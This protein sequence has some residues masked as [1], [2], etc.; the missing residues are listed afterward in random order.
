MAG[1]VRF[2]KLVL[3]SP[4]KNYFVDF[5]AG[6]NLIAGPMYTGKS[7][8]LELLDYALG[9]STPPNYPELAKCS[10]VLVELVVNGETL[11]LR[12]NLKSTSARAQLYEAGLQQV[13]AGEATPTEVLPRHNQTQPSISLAI[14]E[15]LDLATF[16]VKTAPTKDDSDTSSFSLRDLLF[17]VY[18]DQDRMGSKTSFF[19]DVPAKAI[20]W[21]AAFEIVHEL[22]DA[23]AAA[24]AEA[25]RNALK[26]EEDLKRYLQNA[27]KFLDQFRIPG[28]DD[29]LKEEARLLEELKKAE[30]RQRDHRQVER[31]NLGASTQLAER[32]NRMAEEERTLRAREEELQR[33]ERQLGRLR[34]QY[35]RE[36]SQWEFLRESHTIMGSIPV[37]LCPACLQNVA[38]QDP[39]DGSH[40]GLC[41]QELRKQPQDVPVENQIRAVRRRISDLDGYLED[42]NTSRSRIEQQRAALA[43]A[44][45]ESDQ[46][47]RRVNE[48]TILPATRA[49]LEANELVSMFR[50]QIERV[51]EQLAFRR[52]AQ[53]EGSNLALLQEKIEKLRAEEE[54]A[55][56]NRLS[57]ED[58]IK[59]LT[60]WYQALLAEIGFPTLHNAY[61]DQATYRP[62]VRGQAYPA[63]SSKGAIALSVTLWHVALLEYAI[64]PHSRSRFPRLLMLDSPLNHVGRAA[65]DPEF[66]DQKLVDAFYTMLRRLHE[67]AGEFQL[68]MVDNHPPP[69]ARDLIAVEFTG[70][71]GVGRYGLI[72]DE[73]PV[74][75]PDAAGS[76]DTQ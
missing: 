71:V 32:R 4:A 69:S 5:H 66:R 11:T 61:I 6:I 38:T 50:K 26:N 12:R 21:K 45:N 8:V 47:L 42:L 43:T 15:R 55:R 70:K 34:V 40:C 20:K 65:D 62:F 51:R 27:R 31:A 9:A 49:I 35:Q 60:A 57:P 30:E 18:I 24:L 3:T 7:S 41:K 48:S 46:T 54:Q 39:N 2:V 76:E 14:L 19:E 74:L 52:R 67:R 37:S 63:L 16:K 36:L 64:K 68:I 17:L 56:Q 72:D 23:S 29:L 59:D 13:L 1:H 44:I 58:V 28:T 25:L 75:P 33:S 53:G 22:F 73:H 10:D